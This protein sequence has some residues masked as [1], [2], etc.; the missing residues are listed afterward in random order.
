[1]AAA[2]EI[3]Y[4]LRSFSA[5]DDRYIDREAQIQRHEVEEGPEIHLPGYTERNG[6][7]NE[8]NSDNLH[9]DLY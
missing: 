9:C 1:V 3:N 8:D 5:Q 4:P 2:S 7:V 6:H